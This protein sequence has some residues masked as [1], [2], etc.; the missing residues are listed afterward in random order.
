MTKA[1]EG[2]TTERSQRD[3]DMKRKPEGSERSRLPSGRWGMLLLALLLSSLSPAQTSPDSPLP[4]KAQAA[5][6]KG[7]G[8][9]KQSQWGAAIRDFNEAHQLAPD[10]A[11]P[12]LN[13]GLAEAQLSGH[14]LRAFCWFEA[15]LAQ[16][17]N[18]VNAPA[19]RQQIEDLKVRAAGNSG[20]LIAMLRVLA[21]KVPASD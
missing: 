9:A 10:S 14:E 4:H 18:A 6:E 7:I 2:D 15:Y 16:L 12:L 5:V 1:F 3:C 11:L 17:P 13:L 21:A 19:V 8:E 20:R